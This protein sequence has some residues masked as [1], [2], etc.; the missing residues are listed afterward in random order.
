MD[1]TYVPRY[2]AHLKALTLAPGRDGLN[3]VLVAYALKVPGAD[4]LPGAFKESSFPDVLRQGLKSLIEP[5]DFRISRVHGTGTASLYRLASSADM[6]QELRARLPQFGPSVSVYC[7]RQTSTGSMLKVTSKLG[8]GCRESE[9]NSRCWSARRRL[10]LSWPL[11][12]N[13]RSHAF[14][15]A[16]KQG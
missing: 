1:A 12:L 15:D 4:E 8:G 7:H 2:E 11:P 10:L 3:R 16:S 14:L 5:T 9:A 6:C 13:A